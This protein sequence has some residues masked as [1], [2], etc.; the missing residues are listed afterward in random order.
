MKNELEDRKIKPNNAPVEEDT[1]PSE[2]PKQPTRPQI[3]DGFKE[4]MGY[5]GPRLATLILGGTDAMQ[6]T[7]RLLT[8]YDQL[9]ERKATQQLAARQAEIDQQREIDREERAI[10]KDKREERSLQ[11]REKGSKIRE[12]ELKMAEKRVLVDAGKYE[13]DTYNKY[14]KEF[15][16]RE[17]VKKFRDFSNTMDNIENMVIKGGK[18]PGASLALIARGLSGEVGVLTNQDIERA[19]VNPDLWSKVQRGYYTNFKGEIPP[20]DKQEILTIARMIRE[21]KTNKF[22]D[23][24]TKQAKLDGETLN[25]Q[26]QDMMKRNYLGQVY[27]FGD[28]PEVK[29]EESSE[30]KAEVGLSPEELKELQELEELEK[31]GK[32]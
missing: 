22:R 19:Q 16:S 23:I 27:I 7:D 20:K 15:G 31:Q 14:K 13:K 8:G 6:I 24:A 3:E 30:P 21:E 1:Q 32:L 29:P 25:P 12:K 26:H 2:K 17:D 10:S 4:A 28:E 11:V 9:Q 5:F 18:I